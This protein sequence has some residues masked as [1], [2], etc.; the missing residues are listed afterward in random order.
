V[1]EGGEPV[2][3]ADQVADFAQK[4]V[5]AQLPELARRALL[6]S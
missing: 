2:T 5:A 6:V 3:A 4:T 1:E